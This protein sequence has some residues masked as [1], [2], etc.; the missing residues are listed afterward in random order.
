MT[1]ERE[2]IPRT[3]LVAGGVAVFCALI[4]STAV[5]WLR[6]IQAAYE[7]I[8]QNRAVVAAAGLITP[9]AP[10]TDRELVGLFLAFEPLLVDLS[11]DRRAD[12][13]VRASRA[14]D[15]RSAMNEPERTDPIAPADDAAR[16]GR[17]PRLMPVYVLREGSSL[18]AVVLPV[19]GRGMWST[20]HGFVGLGPDLATIVGASFYEHGETPGI[21]DRIEGEAW[22]ESWRGK[23]MYAADGSLVLR[24]G[25]ASASASPGDRIDAITGATVTATAVERLVRYWFGEDGYGPFLA[26]LRNEAA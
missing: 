10:I 2:S 6:P 1:D 4:V 18:R 20:I 7:S 12:A 23:R 26:S 24:I 16:I 21:G 14:L 8:E 19:Y 15:Y 5:Y 3:L 25:G 13:D 9:N 11:T 17:R 22:L